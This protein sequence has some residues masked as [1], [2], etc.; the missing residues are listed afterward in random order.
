MRS[1]L[2]CEALEDRRLLATYVVSST[3]D[4]G[5]GSLREAIDL[6]NA[7]AG[8]ADEIVFDETLFSTPQAIL[9]NSQL[10][11]ITDALSIAGPGAELLA[12]DGQ[13]QTLTQQAAFSILVINDGKAATKVDVSLSGLTLRNVGDRSALTNAESLT[14][15][16]CDFV[17]NGQRFNA[18][19]ATQSGGA[20]NSSGQLTVV[21]SN[22]QGNYANNGGAISSSGMLLS[23]SSSYFRDNQSSYGGGAILSNSTGGV[24]TISGSTF[25]ENGATGSSSQG[26]AVYVDHG[27][28]RA[29]IETSTFSNNEANQGGAIFNAGYL[30]LSH[31][32][33]YGSRVG[34]SVGVASAITSSSQGRV[35]IDHSIV[36]GTEERTSGA[37]RQDLYRVLD[38]TNSLIGFDDQLPFNGLVLVDGENGNQIGGE[39]TPFDPRLAPL[40]DHG[41]PT[42][43]HAPLP[44]SRVI[45]AG[46]ADYVAA[47]GETD[48]RGGL[49]QRVAGGRIDIGAFE[50]Q[51]PVTTA[52][53]DFNGDGRFDAA[54]YT[55]WRDS[56]GVSVAP[57]TAGDATG[58]G[59]VDETD[60]ALWRNRY[61][62]RYLVGEPVVNDLADDDDGDIYNG[63][64]T[65]REAI[66]YANAASWVDTITFDASL[67]G[68]VITQLFTGGFGAPAPVY[69]ISAD[70]TIDA[71]S[72]EEGVTIRS[73]VSGPP[74]L[75]DVYDGPSGSHQLDVTFAGITLNSKRGGF[76]VNA[77]LE[78]SLTFIKS[79]LI[80]EGTSASK[81]S[82]Y[83]RGPIRFVDTVMDLSGLQHLFPASDAVRSNESVELLRSNII[84]APGVGVAVRA[85]PSYYTNPIPSGV[86]LIDSSISG[87]KGYGIDAIG[88]VTLENSQVVAG[89]STGIKTA[90]SK[91]Y[92]GEIVF[93]GSVTLIDGQVSDNQRVGI[94]AAGDVSALRSR[95]ERNTGTGLGGGIYAQGK[96]SLVESYVR[97]NSANQGAGVYALGRSSG[98]FTAPTAETIVVSSQQSDISF[99]TSAQTASAI[100]SLGSIDIQATS[101]SNNAIDPG[102]SNEAIAT[103]LNGI[104][105]SNGSLRYAATFTDSV[106]SGNT[107]PANAR[108]A[109]NYSPGTVTLL[110]SQVIDNAINGVAAT[111]IIDSLI[112]RNQG[113]GAFLFMGEVV[114]SEISE[115]QGY[116]VWG[117]GTAVVIDSSKIHG[118]HGGVYGD[119]GSQIVLVNSTVTENALAPLPGAA[120]SRGAG[121]YGYRVSLYGSTVSDNA[122]T[123]DGA[124]G[125]GI[126]ATDRLD[127][128][129]STVSGNRAEGVGAAGGGVYTKTLTATHSTIANN[130]ADSLGGG[131]Y[132]TAGVSLDGTILAG[133]TA[134]DGGP[135]LYRAGT[136]TLTVDYSLLGDATDSGVDAATGVGNLLGVDPLLGPLQDNGGPTW[137]HALLAGS[138]AIDAGDPARVAV[139]WNYSPGGGL[140]PLTF[141]GDVDQRGEGYPR[142]LDGGSG[143]M[144]IDIGAYEADVAPSLGLVQQTP[145]SRSSFTLS[146]PASLPTLRELDAAQQLLLLAVRVGTEGAEAVGAESDLTPVPTDDDSSPELIDEAFASASLVDRFDRFTAAF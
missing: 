129:Q 119:F 7:S 126:Y 146:K 121:M 69:Q 88:D 13:K 102:S 18:P 133:N 115:N 112:S 27:P 93:P 6:A 107:G 128:V 103:V 65:L 95:I 117:A 72:L 28:S 20:I 60:L 14:V 38:V 145:E 5:A 100:Y 97:S 15:T 55:V 101:I 33:V 35:S 11:T 42:P 105:F 111:S 123:D 109:N 76:I 124:Q 80:A 63:R 79:T 16:D 30:A 51:G 64:T 114:R 116:G 26:G 132:A 113:I 9:L 17:D 66:R 2:R 81:N 78:A 140:P 41:G 96:V 134:P 131:V 74:Q 135:D 130:T 68:G 83:S 46:D 19:I 141:V 108:V 21:G 85:L 90:V 98:S 47:P 110:R 92:Y 138:P 31:S 61:G 40:A 29:S 139:P 75:F 52:P 44:G 142:V 43:T 24:L 56:A 39:Q 122:A 58:D 57:L 10:P 34:F 1:R 37:L 104:Q 136:G 45:D 53:G 82:V 23:V 48:Q 3:A 62:A 73:S 25:A 22:F 54:D 89:Q 120:V 137:T 86:R 106:L 143:A 49:Y 125:G 59:V 77:P 84:G 127:L 70:L 99:N 50:S 91:N 67:S 94:D 118:N 87:S 12:L 144:R 71:R 4:A 8:V 32:T 36:A